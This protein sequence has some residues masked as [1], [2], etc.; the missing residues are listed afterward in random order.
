MM[1]A[2]QRLP[3]VAHGP[4]WLVF[5]GW[6]LTGGGLLAWIHATPIGVMRD[7]LRLWQF[8]SLELTFLALMALSLFCVPR[9]MKHLAIS[10]A[11]AW[12][13]VAAASLSFGLTTFVAPKTNR[14][15]YDEQIYQSIGQN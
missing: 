5:A 1:V 9:L 13:P 14:I 7:H 4:M 2:E 12:V 6:L 3:R 10:L 11:D 8:W 15:Y